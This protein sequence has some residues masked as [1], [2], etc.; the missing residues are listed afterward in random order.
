MNSS[1]DFN[2]IKFK[3]THPRALELKNWFGKKKISEHLQQC[4]NL[5]NSVSSIGMISE[6]VVSIAEMY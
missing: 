1:G 4:K 2:D 3:I 5:S 6:G